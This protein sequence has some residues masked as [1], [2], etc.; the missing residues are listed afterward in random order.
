M[1]VL[2]NEADSTFPDLL[3]KLGDGQ[4][5]SQNCETDTI[6]LSEF[7][8]EVGN[9]DALIDNVFPNFSENHLN[10][11]WLTDRAILSALNETVTKI[12]DK[13]SDRLSTPK[14]TYISINRMV[15][16]GES[17]QFPVEFLNSIEMSGLPPHSL[18][19]KI[20]MPVMLMRSLKPP[21]LINGTRCVVI[22]CYPNVAEVEIVTGTYK[23]QRHFIP[24]IPLE[25]SDTQLPFKFQRRQLPIQ[26]CFAMTINK[27]QGQTLKSVG[28]DLRQP[29]FNHGMLYVALSRTGDKKNI[30][31][32]APNGSTRN[33][34]YTEVL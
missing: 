2:I 8:N 7:G 11:V 20:G 23:G 29:V 28:L 3:L 21:E 9:I 34:V 5:L 19:L 13:L 32:L 12:N 31:Y 10:P 26:P 1:R 22:S 17:V 25:P 14:I 18:K 24:R 33:V 4:L 6:S 16:D 15:N 30:Y 27:A